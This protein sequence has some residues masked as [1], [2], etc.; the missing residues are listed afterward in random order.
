MN[1]SGQQN[2]DEISLKELI[3]KLGDWLSYFF[4]KWKIIL[5][6]L[7]LGAILGY[8]YAST[9]KP[10]YTAELTFALE[11]KQAPS[12]GAAF[13]IAGQLGF[14]FGSPGQ[15]M[16]AGDNLLELMQSKSMIKKTLLTQVDVK[17]KQQALA[18][19]Y[20]DFKELRE[21]WED[22]VLQK[23]GFTDVSKLSFKQDSL[24]NR[25]Y[26]AILTE[27]LSVE[28]KDRKLS[29]IV[30]RVNSE[31]ELFSKYFAEVLVR[32]VADFYVDTR[33][34]RETENVAILQ[35]QT[36]S[37][38]RRLNA[39]ISGSA[40]SA[41]ANPN[42]NP[43][44]Q[45]LRVPAQSRQVDVQTNTA[46]LSELVKN[47]EA[48]R[49][50]LRRETPLV[51]VIDMPELPLEV[52]KMSVFKGA[53]VGGLLGTFFVLVLLIV[54]A[55]FKKISSWRKTRYGIEGTFRGRTKPLATGTDGL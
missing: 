5:V 10:V 54:R 4:S 12:L 44:L 28:R 18:D 1:N 6:G 52:S 20:I 27:N 39:A 3:L 8:V 33:T 34:K 47:L 11:D 22:P 25:F 55:T 53:V 26:R 35:H 49:V 51:Q 19:L 38:R 17:G 23:I 31:S 13:G 37:V 45:I 15:G 32:T 9:Q 14:D 42:P 24:L 7:A 46:I 30:A 41:D 29:I 48:A 50:A 36:D 16:F 40:T 43:A 2:K 21:E